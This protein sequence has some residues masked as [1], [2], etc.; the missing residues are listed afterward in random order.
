MNNI[1]KFF[2]H[3]PS[4]LVESLHDQLRTTC[5]TYHVE[6]NTIRSHYLTRSSTKVNTVITCRNQTMFNLTHR[7]SIHLSHP[8]KYDHL[9]GLQ[10]SNVIWSKVPSRNCG[11]CKSFPSAT[12][13]MRLFSTARTTYK[14][15]RIRTV[16]R[17]GEEKQ[18]DIISFHNRTK[19]AIQKEGMLGGRE[20][21]D[22]HTT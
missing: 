14:L 8:V 21:L 1:S 17:F 2:W 20:I 13:L 12:V 6:I 9:Q 18:T 3:A 22:K 19:C 16:S 7:T 4:G 11:H 10:E 5:T 15:S